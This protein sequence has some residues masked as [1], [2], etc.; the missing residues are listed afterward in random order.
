MVFKKGTRKGQAAIEFLMTYGW[1]LLVVLIVGA[2]IF[3]FVDFGGLLPNKVELSNSL[4]GDQTG[5]VAYSKDTPPN[6]NQVKILFKYTGAK[7]SLIPIDNA[8][9][10]TELGDQ[11]N[12]TE[13]KNLDTGDLVNTTTTIRKISIINSQE[14]LATFDCSVVNSNTGLIKG[15]SLVGKI[16]IYVENPKAQTEVPSSGSLRLQI[17]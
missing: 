3:S 7:R 15:D 17:I 9:I 11:C 1:M 12:A 16:T 2:L 14:A 10:V 13:I 5:S 6:N 8:K 4:R